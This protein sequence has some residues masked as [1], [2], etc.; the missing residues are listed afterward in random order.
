MENRRKNRNWPLVVGLFLLLLSPVVY[1]I[2]KN[3]MCSGCQQ[4]GCALCELPPLLLSG[5]SSLFG[6][7]LI[8]VS[9]RCFKRRLGIKQIFCT[10][11][12]WFFIVKLG[13]I[14]IFALCNFG[15]R[16]NQGRFDGPSAAI[17]I[18]S[19][20]VAIILFAAKKRPL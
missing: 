7:I 19:I 11:I 20:S 5:C 4:L 16:L 9:Y 6:I 13:I 3:T 15:M 18:I 8:V 1:S 10:T 12:R 2:S 14:G 17:A